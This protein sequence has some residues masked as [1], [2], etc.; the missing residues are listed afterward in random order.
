[1]T[2]KFWEPKILMFLYFRASLF[3]EFLDE[4]LENGPE[5]KLRRE[6]MFAC[7]HVSHKKQ[8]ELF[9]FVTRAI[10]TCCVSY[11]AGTVKYIRN[12]ILLPKLFWP[13]VRKNCP[14]D[15]EK[16]YEIR[17]W[18]PRICKNFEIT[19]TIYSNNERSEQFFVKECFFNLFLE[20]SHI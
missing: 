5:F 9:C 11:S 15:R 6:Q 14:S 2:Q 7:L 4:I 12:G 10:L 3:N 17:G 8:P 1:M 19:R 13:T 20:V 16:T 18:R